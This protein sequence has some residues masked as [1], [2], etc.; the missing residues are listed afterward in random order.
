MARH[1]SSFKRAGPKFRSEA[2][3][4]VICEDS[5]SS[6]RYLQSAANHNRAHVDVEI[7]HC[8]RTDPLGI[9][10]EGRK[11]SGGY[12]RIYCVIDRDNHDS[13]REALE[14][15]QNIQKM[16]V[17]A[18]YPC[19]EFWL[20]LH[21]SYNRKPYTSVGQKSAADR[22]VDE[23]R[24]KPGMERYEK[25]SVDDIFLKLLG[26]YFEFAKRVAPQVLADAIQ[27]G[28]MN[29]STQVYQLIELFEALGTP[30]LLRAPSRSR[31]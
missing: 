20:L 14:L 30:E 8:G 24:S 4:L 18:S 16:K 29:P 2:R 25:G 21:F 10:N 7:T 15:A 1:A 19:F 31:T 9:V 26:P 22:V 23:L 17:I 13:F 6:L 11:R 3:I 12:D 5:K 27:T 28:E